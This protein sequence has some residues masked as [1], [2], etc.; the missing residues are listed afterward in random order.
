VGF[1][2]SIPQVGEIRSAPQHATNIDGSC[3]GLLTSRLAGDSRFLTVAVGTIIAGRR[4]VGPVSC[5]H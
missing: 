5:C 4:R 1:C 2:G 3:A